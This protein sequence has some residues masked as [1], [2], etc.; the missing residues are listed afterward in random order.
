MYSDIIDYRIVGDTKAALL[1]CNPFISN[2][3]RKVHELS[4]LNK[5]AIKKIV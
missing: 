3:Y 4:T 5:F 1:R 2:I